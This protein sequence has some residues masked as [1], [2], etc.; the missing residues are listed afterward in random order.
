MKS[1]YYVKLTTKQN[2]KPL[3]EKHHYLSKIQRGFKSGFNYALYYKGDIVGVCI[4]TGIPV[5][6]LLKGMLGGDFNDS[7]EGLFELSRLVLDPD[8]QEREHNMAGWFASKSIML[9]R[10]HTD[11]RLILSYADDGFHQG[12]VYKAL[13]FDYYGLSAP[14]KDF[15]F[16]LEDGTFLKHSRGTVK[17]KKG[18]WRPRNRKHRFLKVFDESLTI[19]WT[20]L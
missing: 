5:K 12:T 15:W 10:R 3:L 13:G 4:F 9:L 20:K 6:E 17:G 1:D 2:V 8:V 19:Q 16:E 11:V 7:Q 14:K 18:E